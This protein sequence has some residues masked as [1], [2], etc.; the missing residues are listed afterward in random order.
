MIM[1]PKYHFYLLSCMETRSCDPDTTSLWRY[2][3]KD[4][5]TGEEHGFADTEALLAFLQAEL[6]GASDEWRIAN[7]ESDQSAV[8]SKQ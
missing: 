5:R 7:D 3:L 2:T 8:V 4:P 1:P 6:P